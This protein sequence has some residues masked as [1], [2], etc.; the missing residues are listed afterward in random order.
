[1]FRQKPEMIM[2]RSSANANRFLNVS[3]RIISELRTMFHRKGDRT[4]P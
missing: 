1:M 2:A 3:R 4:P